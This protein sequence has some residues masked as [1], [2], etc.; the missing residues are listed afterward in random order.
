MKRL[1]IILQSNVF[2]IFLCIIALIYSLIFTKLI[3]YES[4]YDLNETYLE[5]KIIDFNIDG[6]KLDLMISGKEKV[7]AT[8]Y[9]KKEVE[10]DYLV[11]NI[12]VGSS[13]KLNGEFTEP[14]SNTIP[15]TFNYKKYLYNKKIYRIF[16]ITNYELDDKITFF[17]KLKNMI[18]KRINS[19]DDLSPYF[20]TFILGDK[21]ELSLNEYTNY[22]TNGVSHLFAIS[23]MH[24][25]LFSLL[26]FFVLK[27]INVTEK[28]SFILVFGFLAFYAFL[29]GFPASI[30]RALVFMLFLNLNKFLGLQITNIKCLLLTIASILL[31]N[32]F[33]LYDLGFQYSSITVLSLLLCADYIQGNYF[34][35]TFKVSI[36]AF[37]FS[38][39]ITLYNFYEINLLSPFVNLLFV[40][41][42]S[43]IVYPLVLLNFIFSFLTPITLIVLKFL[44]LINSFSAS[45]NLFVLNIPKLSFIVVILLYILLLI[46]IKTKRKIFLVIAFVLI[47]MYKVKPLMDSS[48]Y[49]YFLDVGQGDSTVVILPHQKKVIMIDTGGELTFKQEE[50]MER[51]RKYKK[52]TNTI[53]FLKSL[54]IKT[55]DSLILSHGDADH[56]GEAIN[57]VK[58]INVKNIMFNCGSYNNLEKNLIAVLAKK[59]IRNESCIK[60]LNI[61]NNKLYFLNNKEYGNENDNS[62]VIYAKL[63]N[64]KLLFMGDAGVEVEEDLI[65]KYNLVDIDVL[66]VGHHG[67]KTSSGK[68]FID[69][70]NPKYSIISV[71]K[72]NRYGHPNSDVLDSLKNS[73]IYR[74][75][76][77]G[78]VMF[79]IKNDKLKIEACEP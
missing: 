51:K 71:G 16:N 10:K 23:G 58:N 56:M 52:S 9:I 63:N 6:N 2:Y 33:M 26:L 77:D 8:Y 18:I 55:I 39:P 57:L 1:K 22:Q 45:L 47:F 69:E 27:K 28:K 66:K 59:R 36:M 65:N 53:S 17:Y 21:R 7:N 13:I 41:F 46:F 24:I 73:Q 11:E 60:E 34:I 76:M 30:V 25:S 44:T 75:D 64:H 29:T 70:T 3:K 79:K 68:V 5:G 37:I 31:F 50:W 20:K 40:P 14:I 67:S 49:I 74:T 54:G 38:M 19:N 42:I 12:L 4:V 72:N 48:T 43:Y 61:D 62:S 78:S 15:N 35:R 32:P